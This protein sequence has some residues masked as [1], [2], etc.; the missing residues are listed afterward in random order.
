[1]PCPQILR[2]PAH[3]GRESRFMVFAVKQGHVPS[4]ERRFHAEVKKAT[5]GACL[6]SNAPDNLSIISAWLIFQEK[7]ILA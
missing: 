1:M 5:T 7:I 2:E 3:K 4:L 6:E